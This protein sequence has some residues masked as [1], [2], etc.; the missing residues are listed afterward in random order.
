LGAIVALVAA[1]AIWGSSFPVIRSTMTHDLWWMLA[2]R[3]F[4]GAA[5]VLV[6]SRGRCLA[7]P[8]QA[9]GGLVRIGLLIGVAFG[10]QG[11][12]ITGTSIANSSVLSALCVVFTPT[13]CALLGQ[14]RPTPGQWI[15]AWIGAAAFGV[16]GAAQ[17]FGRFTVYDGVTVIAALAVALHTIY[18]GAA[19]AEPGRLL[20]AVFYQFMVAGCVLLLGHFMFE[21]WRVTM[22]TGQLAGL[23]YLGVTGCG[24]A[25]VLQAYGQ[26]R[27]SP[28]QTVL[29]IA[30]EPLWAM[31]IARVACGDPISGPAVVAGGLLLLANVVAERRRPDGGNQRTM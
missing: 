11:L 10:T 23:A 26:R 7:A 25:F 2:V 31:A 30:T 28:V 24:V 18:F 14:G 20:S 21:P 16:L 15:G 3:M 4:I 5:S 6:L 8:R 13:L 12:G 17:G 1:T 19:V 22:T 9:R 29:I 27:L